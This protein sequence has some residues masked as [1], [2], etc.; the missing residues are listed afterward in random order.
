MVVKTAVGGQ[1]LLQEDLGNLLVE[2]AEAEPSRA[3]SQLPPP[4]SRIFHGNLSRTLPVFN[5]RTVFYA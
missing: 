5:K 3:G 4:G 1:G 2:E